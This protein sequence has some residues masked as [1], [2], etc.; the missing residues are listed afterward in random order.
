[1]NIYTYE[2]YYNIYELYLHFYMN[3]AD[4]LYHSIIEPLYNYNC[5]YKFVLI[6]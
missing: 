4:P 2:L 6:R 3:G 1:M 5:T